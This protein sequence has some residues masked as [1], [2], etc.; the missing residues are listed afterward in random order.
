MNNEWVDRWMN[1]EII[2]LSDILLLLMCNAISE[3]CQV[4]IYVKFGFCHFLS[5]PLVCLYCMMLPGALLFFN[6][7][8]LEI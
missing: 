7:R 1:W 4:S 3:K 6:Y 8:S 5:V 2:P